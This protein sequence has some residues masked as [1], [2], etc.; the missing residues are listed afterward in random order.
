LSQTASGFNHAFLWDRAQGMSDLGTLGGKESQS[1]AIND[2]GQVFGL[3]DTPTRTFCPFLCDPHGGMIP[4]L[5]QTED[6]Y[7]SGINN[8]SRVVGW[9]R[10]L[11]GRYQIVLWSKEAGLQKVLELDGD[12]L[13]ETPILNDAGQ[14]VFG[15]HVNDPLDTVR[16]RIFAPRWTYYVWDPNHGKVPLD[17]C[18][19]PRL[20]EAFWPL[21]I[22][23][24]GCIVGG[25]LS[26]DGRHGRA[27]LLE[28]IPE[29]WRK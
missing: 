8:G 29:R 24:K 18:L 26:Q 9:H 12:N 15:E 7:F 4:L 10:P 25:F 5:P 3:A 2:A 6:A 20:R 27:V 21:D 13:Q 22:N 28:P 17:P 19:R 23:N 14:I 11:G 16:G 1:R